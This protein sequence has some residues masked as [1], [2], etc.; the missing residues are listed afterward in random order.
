MIA[1]ALTSGVLL[2]ATAAVTNSLHASAH[3]A[4]KIALRDDALSALADVR[5]A[6]AYDPTLLARMAGT[7]SSLTIARAGQAPETITIAV[8]PAAAAAGNVV[9]TAT[10]MQNAASV[11]EQ[12]TL[13]AEAP[14]PG[15][16]VKQ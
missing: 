14:A 2:A 4:T 3:E 8:A 7:S 16:T 13:Y 12:R 11:T 10:A 15:S 9:A 6:T 5:A 1:I